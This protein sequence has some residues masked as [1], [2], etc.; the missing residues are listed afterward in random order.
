MSSNDYFSFDTSDEHLHTPGPEPTW[1]ES[2][3]FVAVDATGP[4]LFLRHGRRHNEGHIEVTVAQLNL[5][6]SLDVMF[7]KRPLDAEQSADR[8][9]SSGGGLA[10]TLIEPAKRW[11]STYQGKIKKIASYQAFADDPRAALGDASAAACSFDLLFEDRGPLFGSGPDGAIPGGDT[12]LSARHYESTVH[13]VGDITIDDRTRH[14]ETYGFRDH[15]WGKRD[16]TLAQFTRWFWVQHDAQTSC[17]GWF[18]RADGKDYSNGIILREGT[19]EVA[20][21]A[22]LTSRYATGSERYVQSA[23]LELGSP[24]GTIRTEIETICPL[25]LRYQKD[26]R[27]TRVVEFASRVRGS[28]WPAWAEYCD[29]MVDGIPVGNQQ[30]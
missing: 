4:S 9:T 5:D 13:C 8:G 18:T 27:T 15:S 23:V 22:T 25:P 2:L 6:G 16:M 11:R 20:T 14:I 17:F 26:G 30:A 29:Q 1:N 7:A 3:A 19:A 28:N 21:S 10:F 12:Y 24:Q